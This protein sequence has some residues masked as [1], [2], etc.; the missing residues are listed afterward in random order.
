MIQ[1]EMVTKNYCLRAE[2]E[3]RMP[4]PDSELFCSKAIQPGDFLAA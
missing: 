1:M 3:E 2:K 4:K